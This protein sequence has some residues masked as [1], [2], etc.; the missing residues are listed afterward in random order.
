MR[1]FAVIGLYAPKTST[2][3]GHVLRAAHCF[4]AVLVVV[5]GKRY[6]KAPTDCTHASRHLPLINNTLL[7][8][9][10]HGAIS[11]AVEITDNAQ[12]LVNF[13]HPQS[14]YY[15]F[16]PEDGSLPIHII[17][18]CQEVVSIPSTYCLNL[19]MTV[20]IVLYDRMSKGV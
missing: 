1:G 19:A 3:V 13:K 15:M 10:P 20:N 4:G 17:E 6:Q 16:G 8:V 18:N 2:N 9:K 14:A 11:I 7:N 5:E 12:S